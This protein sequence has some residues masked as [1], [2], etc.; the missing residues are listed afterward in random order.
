[1]K[2]FGA[3]APMR[4]ILCLSG[5]GLWSFLSHSTSSSHSGIHWPGLNWSTSFLEIWGQ[6]TYNTNQMIY[7]CGGEPERA[8]LNVIAHKPWITAEFV[9]I[10]CSMSY[11]HTWTK[12]H[13]EVM[14]SI[15][16]AYDHDRVL[17]MHGALPEVN[18]TTVS[19]ICTVCGQPALV[20][21]GPQLPCAC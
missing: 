15:S 1:M 13:T 4:F 2:L 9:T 7:H 21:H 10:C 3:L 18:S 11:T 17:V 12:L 16:G 19:V 6:D 8:M 20:C 5:T 14:S